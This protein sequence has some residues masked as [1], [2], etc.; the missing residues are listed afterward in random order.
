MHTYTRDLQ[1]A[2]QRLLTPFEVIRDEW[3]QTIMERDMK[4]IKNI[5]DVSRFAMLNQTVIKPNS[6]VNFSTKYRKRYNKKSLDNLLQNQPKEVDNLLK[7]IKNET[8][9]T[10]VNDWSQEYIDQYEKKKGKKYNGLA[11]KQ[12]S[13]KIYRASSVFVRSILSEFVSTRGFKQRSISFC[14]FTI[15]ESQKHSD[16][17]IIK[18]FVDF[19]DHL[20]KVNNYIIDPV[21]KQRTK[22]KALTIENYIWRAETQ[23]NG[24][25]HFHMIADTFLNQ[26]MLRRVWN[27]YLQGLGYKYS[28]SAANVNSLKK[29]KNGNKIGNVE[30]YLCKYLTK[31]PLRNA[32]KH[33]KLKD[34]EGIADKDKFRRPIIG[35]SWGC[36]R[37]LLKLE[38]P[39]F[40]DKGAKEIITK[41]RDKMR[42]IKSDNLPEYIRVYVGNTRQAILE[43]DYGT[44]RIIKEH[45]MLCYHWLYDEIPIE[46]WN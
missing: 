8:E 34:L 29:D 11:S 33:C 9:I 27:N 35:K 3:Y 4:W 13:D 17:E 7:S 19:I 37:K 10:D 24:N 36:S 5:E 23:E 6:M 15:S 28:Y 25:I 2:K 26:D 46:R 45:Y 43:L 31:P 39:K 14:T 30:K 38:Y 41:M 1:E 32:Y 44:Q 12:V 42:E 18:V 22:E 21:T 20:K 40:Y 16:T